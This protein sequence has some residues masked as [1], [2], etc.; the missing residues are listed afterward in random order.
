M[1]IK[2][3]ALFLLLCS[4]LLTGQN[5]SDFSPLD[6]AQKIEYL[7]TFAKI[8]GYVKYFHPSDEAA[9]INWDKF[10]IYGAQKIGNCISQKD[11][12]NT[13]NELFLPIAPSIKFYRTGE[14]VSFDFRAITPSNLKE[15]KSTYWQHTGVGLGM[16]SLAHES[17]KST[18]VN[19][20]TAVQN[21]ARNS[22]DFGIIKTQLDATKYRSKKIKLSG[23]CRITDGNVGTGHLWLRIDNAQTKGV[24]FNNMFDD[25]ITQNKW[26]EYEIVANVDSLATNIS[27][28][29]FLFGEGE[30][31][32]DNLKLHYLEN[33]NWI[34][35]PIK[36]NDFA[37]KK[38]NSFTKNKTWITD[39]HN[40]SIT[41]TPLQSFDRSNCLSIKKVN[42]N[43]L[44]G[45]KLFDK[46]P[47]VGELINKSIG[48]GI[49]CYIPLV[50][51]CNE[52]STF[53]S[54]IKNNL[55]SALLSIDHNDLTL[56]LRWGDIINAWNV[57]Q[58]FYPYFDVTKVNWEEELEK[59]LKKTYNDRSRVDFLFTLQTLTAA[60]KDGHIW[61]SGG[62]QKLY[63]PAI[64]WEFI[65]NQ[66]TITKICDEKLN[67]KVGDIVTKIDGLPSKMYF[68]IIN[69]RISAAT[70]G[71]LN[72]RANTMSLSGVEN[73]KMH[74]TIN[75]SIIE[76]VR[77]VEM[78]SAKCDN[79]IS[80]SNIVHKNVGDNIMYLN[81]ELI[82]MHT[83]DSLLPQLKQAKAI[84][85]DLRGYPNS[86]HDFI[87]YLLDKNDTNKWMFVP[88]IIYPD[89]ENIVGYEKYGWD[90][91]SK[92]PHLSAKI[93]FIIDGHAISYAESYLGFIE[94]YN[95]ATLVGQPSAGTNGNMNSFL[96]P[97]GYRISFT[98][99]KVLKHNGSRLHGIGIVP[100]ILVSKTIKGVAEGRDEFLEKAIDIA[101]EK[102]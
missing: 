25:P 60:L 95:L 29:C 7:K 63:T 58:H 67:L 78:N 86:N 8:Y 3:I 79:S 16:N 70:E 69:S 10:A 36:N 96:L 33:E 71:W 35:I 54:A 17:Y 2:I 49:S 12:F 27:L 50:L 88:H 34:E 37:G 68:E 45:E 84:I 80:A 14:N 21:P 85:C 13:L 44:K 41:I 59:A 62:G 76:L 99:M 75:D 32:I 55:D 81:M 57:F 22:S 26:E 31:L 42:S 87:S 100:N 97:A 61:V 1:K 47:S 23:M 101:N 83:I 5:K 90:L 89:H 74:I 82:S 9:Q 15:Y 38:I 91:K 92:K 66:L 53:P 39:G 72:H 51:Y 56:Y 48:N 28:G 73:S 43:I 93:I 52:K 20:H 18:R 77:N 46:G 40:Y 64:K 11:L 98:G 19:R 94:G 4:K 102:K 30:F 65:E 6:T 24:F